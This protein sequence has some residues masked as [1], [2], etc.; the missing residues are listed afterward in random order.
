M[1]SVRTNKK[2]V[3]VVCYNEERVYNTRE[4]AIKFFLE[5]CACSEGSEQSRYSN[6]LTGLMLTNDEVV[7]DE[8]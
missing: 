8:Y 6:I 2:S 5:C 7:R 1:T 3:K 4:E